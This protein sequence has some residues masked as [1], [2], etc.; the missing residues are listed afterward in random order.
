MAQSASTLALLRQGVEPAS[1]C[2]DVNSYACVKIT[3]PY[4]CNPPNSY[5]IRTV[6]AL[7]VGDNTATLFVSGTPVG[8]P[9]PTVADP[10]Y[11]Y[12]GTVLT[13]NAA[14][15]PVEIKVLQTTALT[16]ATAGVAV[17]I[18]DA[19]AIVATASNADLYRFH[20]LEGIQGVNGQSNDESEDT[21]KNKDGIQKSESVVSRGI[22]YSFTTFLNKSDRGLWATAK[23]LTTNGGQD[24][25]ISVYGLPGLFD[26]GMATF[27]NGSIDRQAKSKAKMSFDAMLNAPY[28]Q[29]S[30]R[31][32]ETAARQALLDELA[33]LW[34]YSLADFS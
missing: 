2:G 3:M 7:A 5:E 22:T 24:G 14:T 9:A 6:G 21:T 4:D 29:F 15:T 18:E 27:M 8:A 34:G 20:V 10:F 28:D 31:S 17:A 11:L 23:K 16:T 26:V 25:L 19:P 12:A 13:F 1:Q 33:R 32:T 30:L